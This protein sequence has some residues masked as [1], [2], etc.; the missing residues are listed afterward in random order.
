MSSATADATFE[1]EQQLVDLGI[2]INHKDRHNRVPLHYAF[3]KISKWTETHQ[4]D[5]IETV[6][7]MCGCQGL[8][9]DEPDVWQK[10]PLHYAA[11][12]GASIS[13]LYIVAR[14]A[15]LENTDVYGNTPLGCA[16]LASHFNYC[17]LLIQR[18]SKVITKVCDEY[19]AFVAYQ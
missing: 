14:G 19:P 8:K 16:L 4:L 6:S 9:L 3:V 1:T 11:R 2:D 10:T 7:S 15:A 13:T 18:G 5:P 17:I 12:R